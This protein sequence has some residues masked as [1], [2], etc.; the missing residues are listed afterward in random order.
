MTKGFLPKL[1]ACVAMSGCVIAP[2]TANAQTRADQ[3]SKR[4]QEK[5][6]EWR[7]LAYLGAAAGIYGL[8]KGDNT[9]FF[10]GTAGT[11]YSLHRYEQDRKSQSRIDRARASA[12]SRTYFYRDGKR[13]KRRLVTLNGKKYYQFVRA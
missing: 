7:N 10:A 6:N 4:R 13:Y 8:L 9:L 1:L 12:F 5:K 11:L 3:E 2:L